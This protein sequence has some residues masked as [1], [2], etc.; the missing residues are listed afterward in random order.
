M[1]NS[2]TGLKVLETFPSLYFLSFVNVVLI[3]VAV[4]FTNGFHDN[5]VYHT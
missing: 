2:I 5:F 3:F 4:C 1:L